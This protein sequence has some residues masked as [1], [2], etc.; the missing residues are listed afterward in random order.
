MSIALAEVSRDQVAA[1]LKLTRRVAAAH[2]D[3]LAGE[4]WL[5]VSYRRLGGRTGPGAGRTSKLYRRSDKRVEV[6]V[7]AR[8]YELMAR[9]FASGIEHRPAVERGARAYGTA[10]GAAARFGAGEKAGRR[11]LLSGL[12]DELSERGFEPFLDGDVV[13]L[14]NCPFHEMARENSDLVCA[15]NLALMQGA[16]GGLGTEGIVPA[17]EPKPGLC[18]VAFHITQ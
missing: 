5:E 9:L 2:L 7:P 16:V 11:E 12:L 10:I 4:G 15:T 3:R 17:L 1:N 6:S 13:R 18:C 14:R 8:N